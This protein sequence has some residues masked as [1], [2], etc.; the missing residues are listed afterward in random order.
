MFSMFCL[1][2]GRLAGIPDQPCRVGSAHQNHTH[3]H[4]KWWAMPTLPGLQKKLV[5]ASAM[6]DSSNLNCFGFHHIKDKILS[7]NQHTISENEVL[8]HVVKIKSRG[9]V[10][11]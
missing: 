7:D 11:K 9:E 5:L 1:P 6:D 3:R 8:I 10:Y 4:R 2:A